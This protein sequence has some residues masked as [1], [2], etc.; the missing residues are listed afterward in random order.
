MGAVMINEM[1]KNL[2]SSTQ[3]NHEIGLNTR[4]TKDDIH[5]LKILKQ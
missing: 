2:Q 1:S 5:E 4:A 3:P